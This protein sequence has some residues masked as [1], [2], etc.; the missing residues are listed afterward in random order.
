[1]TQLVSLYY[2]T[3]CVTIYSYKTLIIKYLYC[4]LICVSFE[5][6]DDHEQKS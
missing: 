5:V 1:M 3:S 6:P 4:F 2:D